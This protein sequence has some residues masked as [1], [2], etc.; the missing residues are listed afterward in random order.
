MRSKFKCE[1]LFRQSPHILHEFLSQPECLIRWFCD[2][3]DLIDEKYIFEWDGNQEYAIVLDDFQEEFLKIKWE[4]YEDGEMQEYRISQSEVTNET[5]LEISGYCD[6]GEEKDEVD[7]WK[8][9]IDALRRA[10]GG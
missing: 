4:Y 5:I 7:F 1:F 2:K 10:M 3:C 9:K 6:K 8:L